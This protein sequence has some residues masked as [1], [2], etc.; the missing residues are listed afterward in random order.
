MPVLRYFAVVGGALLALLFVCNTLFPQVSF[1][2]AVKPGSGL[3]TVRIA[4]E[5]KWPE[6]VV[7]DTSI[8]NGAPFKADTTQQAT[9][10]VDAQ[11]SNPREAFAQ[12]EI[13]DPKQQPTRST[14]TAVKAAALKIADA[15]QQKAAERRSEARA[16]AK[17]R[18][19]AKLHPAR[20]MIVVA[21]QPQPHFGFFD[22]T[23]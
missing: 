12:M 15:T 11:K 5:R 10:A 21:Q 7:F 1:P 18:L 9:G 23:W 22:M 19:V 20:P 3:P 6:R 14:N 2:E 13:G 4:S 16:Q 8:P 17:R